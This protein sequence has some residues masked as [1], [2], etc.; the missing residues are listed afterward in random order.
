MAPGAAGAADAGAG[1]DADAVRATWEALTDVERTA[2]AVVFWRARAAE[3]VTDPATGAP[4]FSDPLAAAAVARCIPAEA[5]AGM[6]ARNKAGVDRIGWMGVR[7]GEIDRRVAEAAAEA[8]AV[9]AGAGAGAG[10][11]GA[12]G[13][14]EA[15]STA[16]AAGAGA[17]APPLQVAI[18]G[19]GLDARAWRL[20]WPA[21]VA[22]FEADTAPM[23][24]LKRRV[25]AGFGL[26]PSVAARR[27]VACDL[28]DTAALASGLAAAGH[29]PEA[30]TVWLLEGL[31]GYLTRAEALG[32]LQALWRASA[33]GSRAVVTAPPSEGDRREAEAEG[34]ELHHSTF[35]EAPETMERARAAGWEGRIVSRDELAARYGVARA[36][37]LL[38]L[39]KQ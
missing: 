34:L 26:H 19:A 13:A 32:L 38:L 23:L 17:E 25:F 33:P 31:I 37:A 20:A 9:G 11:A 22:V 3:T 5:A 1:S 8:A 35:E 39:R 6:E 24:A 27:E 29:R 21:R 28:R 30:P 10:A 7:T 4:L 14:A 36:Q 15:A 18:L 2:L 16:V 12:A